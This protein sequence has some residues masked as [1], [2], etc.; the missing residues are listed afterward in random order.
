[1]QPIKPTP[2]LDPHFIPAEAVLRT[3]ESAAKTHPEC[4][5]SLTMTLQAG[6]NFWRFQIQLPFQDASLRPLCLQAGERL[7]KS[8][9]WLFGGHKAWV[10]GPASLVTLLQENYGPTGPNQFDAH[11]MGDQVYDQPF[12][13]QASPTADHPEP[14]QTAQKLGGHWRG[15]RIGFDLG[16]SDRKLAAVIDGNV[17][18]AEEVDW[19]PYFEKDPSYHAAGIRDCIERAAEHLPRIDAI[20]GSAAGIYVAN[21]V[22]VA[23]LFR[24]I[25]P[26]KFNQTIRPIFEQI[27]TQYQVP[28]AV[29][30]DG[31]VTALAGALTM[32]RHS[33]LGIAMGTSQAGGFVNRAGNITGALNELAFVPVDWNPDAV[34]DEWSGDYGVGANYFS[35]QAVA[36][37][38]PKAGIVLPSEMS[39]PEQLLCV[40]KMA[41]EGRPEALKIFTTIGDYLAWTLPYYHRFLQQENVLLLGRVT[42]GNGGNHLLHQ[43]RTSLT[44]IAPGL[45]ETMRIEVPDERSK[46]LGQ[47]VA[48][49]SLVPLN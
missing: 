4:S 38:A 9:L 12:L 33:L 14:N 1:M 29:I 34:R 5:S 28:L 13:I 18:H 20:G 21:R 46:R 48:A 7:F 10:D 27:Q 49:A 42:S 30:N 22:R 2:A 31:D 6:H 36:R 26:L 35:Q 45:A 40:Q 43:A 24:G 47:A 15:C 41:D 16:G 39:L 19:Q 3:L 11:F 37:L 23:S 17:V 44:L 32:Q 8:M 25:D